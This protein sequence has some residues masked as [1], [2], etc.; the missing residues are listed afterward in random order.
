MWNNVLHALFSSHY[1]GLV[2]HD[3]CVYLIVFL[4]I[5]IIW[6]LLELFCTVELLYLTNLLKLCEFYC[7]LCSQSLLCMHVVPLVSLVSIH[8]VFRWVN[9][10]KQNRFHT[11]LLSLFYHE[12]V[13]AN[14]TLHTSSTIP[15]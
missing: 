13:Q 2:E 4:A 14:A 3:L 1:Y 5:S 8:C 12:Q 11:Y 6:A 9:T 10:G 15:L 7:V